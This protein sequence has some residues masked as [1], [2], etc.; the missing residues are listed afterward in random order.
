MNQ[1]PPKQKIGIQQNKKTSISHPYM[2]KHI[3]N[4]QRECKIIL[5]NPHSAFILSISEFIQMRRSVPFLVVMAATDKE[6]RMETAWGR[7][8]RRRSVGLIAPP[9][10]FILLFCVALFLHSSLCIRVERASTSKLSY[11][12][13]SI[14]DPASQTS[15]LFCLGIRQR[16]VDQIVKMYT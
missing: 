14:E 15:F 7:G 16:Q 6:R 3:E 4:Q 13:M 2:Q 9:A 5:G 11:S 1:R 10:Q 12:P 8:V